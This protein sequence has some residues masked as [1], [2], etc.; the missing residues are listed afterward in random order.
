MLAGAAPP[1]APSI[2]TITTLGL[3][4]AGH[5]AGKHES[6]PR[7]HPS[8]AEGLRC[9]PAA[10]SPCPSSSI[11]AW[12]ETFPAAVLI[13]LA[14]QPEEAQHPAAVAGW[15]LAEGSLVSHRNPAGLVPAALGTARRAP[16]AAAGAGSV[17]CHQH[18]LKINISDLISPLHRSAPRGCILA[19]NPSPVKGMGCSKSQDTGMHPKVLP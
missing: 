6:N 8:S 5:L 16:L 2:P 19:I 7:D 14:R 10:P 15:L 13:S 18:G 3:F 9:C 12:S 11:P 4:P 17:C 1:P